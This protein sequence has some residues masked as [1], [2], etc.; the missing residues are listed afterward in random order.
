[1]T[2]RRRAASVLA[3]V[4]RLA[5]PAPAQNLYR[6]SGPLFWLPESHDDWAR[7]VSDWLPNERCGGSPYETVDGDEHNPS[8]AWSWVVWDDRDDSALAEEEFASAVI[9]APAATRS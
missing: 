9:H 3:A 5:G 1:M 7:L 8:C 6:G 4:I 2:P